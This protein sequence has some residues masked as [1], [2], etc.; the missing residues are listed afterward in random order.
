MKTVV[1]PAIAALLPRAVP[2]TAVVRGACPTGVRPRGAP[3]TRRLPDRA[4]VRRG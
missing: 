2:L 4:A 3:P 1:P